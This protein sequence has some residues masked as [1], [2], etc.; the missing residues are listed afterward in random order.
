LHHPE[1]P[2]FDNNFSSHSSYDYPPEKS[3]LEDTLK[4][5]M[6]L[7]NQPTI[8][9][10][11]EPSLEDALYAFRQTINQPFQEI[12]PIWQIL[13]LLQGWKDSLVI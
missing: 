3:S 2:Q 11:H 12:M 13:K 4:E 5:F 6:E 8:P 7:V 9:V 10:L 1:Y